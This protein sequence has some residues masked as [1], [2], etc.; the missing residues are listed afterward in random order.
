MQLFSSTACLFLFY[1]QPGIVTQTSSQSLCVSWFTTLK[2]HS[3]SQI[4]ANQHDK[5]CF[6][7]S[8]KAPR[9]LIMTEINAYILGILYSVSC[10]LWCDVNHHCSCVCCQQWFSPLISFPECSNMN[11]L[12]KTL[13]AN[14]SILLWPTH[15]QNYILKERIQSSFLVH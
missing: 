6:T 7:L 9:E 15:L 13:G 3:S 4:C 14:T 2:T 10:W 1:L 12:F 11:Y 5:L 8:M